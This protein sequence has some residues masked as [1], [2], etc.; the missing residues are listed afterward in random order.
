[1]QD[2]QGYIIEITAKPEKS[3]KY[4]NGGKGRDNAD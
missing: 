4:F 2:N 3:L 1:V